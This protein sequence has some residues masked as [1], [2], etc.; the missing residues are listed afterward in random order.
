MRKTMIALLILSVAFF[1]ACAAQTQYLEEATATQATTEAGSAEDWERWATEPPWP[2]QGSCPE[3]EFDNFYRNRFRPIFYSLS[4]HYA[5]L[6]DFAALREWERTRTAEEYHNVNVAVGF[7]QHF[8]ISREDF[9]RANEEKRQF[10]ANPPW[11][12]PF[13]T[14]G[15][16]QETYPVALIFSFDNER[17]N[18]FFRWEN[19]I[20]AHEVGLPNPLR[21]DWDEDGVWHDHPNWIE[22]PGW[23]DHPFWEYLPFWSE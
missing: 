2:D 3:G 16:T 5:R 23:R 13:E 8:N 12:G 22:N 14:Q 9:E 18:E 4:Y 20:Y 21:G 1:A 6:V 11:G 10:E 17:I 19:S 7:I 15:A